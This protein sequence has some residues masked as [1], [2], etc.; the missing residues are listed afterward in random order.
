MQEEHVDLVA[1]DFIGAAWRQSNGNN[2][3]STS[4]LEEALADTF[5]DAARPHTVLGPRGSAR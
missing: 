1:G 3:Q 4:I 2:P 5:S